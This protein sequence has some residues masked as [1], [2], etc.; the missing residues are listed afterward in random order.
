MMRCEAHQFIVAVHVQCVLFGH[1]SR[2][3]GRRAGKSGQ[4]SDVSC[5]PV[6]LI[7][8]LPVMESVRTCGQRKVGYKSRP[9]GLPGDLTKCITVMCSLWFIFMLH[10]SCFP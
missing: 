7:H 5:S 1:W 10:F 4:A 8:S 6:N 9:S 2:D 3:T